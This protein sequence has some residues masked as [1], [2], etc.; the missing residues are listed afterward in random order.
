MY[1]VWFDNEN[2]IRQ[3]W[4][5]TD[6]LCPLLG[7]R[8]ITIESKLAFWRDMFCITL[9]NS[10]LTVCYSQSTLHLRKTQ[11]SLARK[12]N[13]K[14]LHSLISLFSY[15][16]PN[17]QLSPVVASREVRN[18]RNMNNCTICPLTRWLWSME[19]LQHKNTRANK[20]SLCI[21]IHRKIS[22]LTLYYDEV[23]FFHLCFYWDTYF[24]FEMPVLLQTSLH[25]VICHPR[26]IHNQLNSVKELM[27]FYRLTSINGW[28]VLVAHF[29]LQYVYWK[30]FGNEI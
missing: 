4:Q 29:I 13:Y 2:T 19:V 23:C 17:F 18:G 30:K 3:F 20:T 21:K 24:E 6:Q 11:S 26:R 12:V 15:A 16:Q 14:C 10:K 27:C 25:E 22:Y 9:G 5:H 8:T 1:C 7:I 28:I